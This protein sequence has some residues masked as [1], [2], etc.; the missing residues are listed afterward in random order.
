MT[1]KMGLGQQAQASY[2]TRARELVPLGLANRPKAHF[3]NDSFEQ[4]SE[5]FDTPQRFR[6]APSRVNNPFDAIHRW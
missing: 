3:H 6:T 2:S 1:G 5:E 4:R